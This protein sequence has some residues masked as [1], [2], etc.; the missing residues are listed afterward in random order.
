VSRRARVFRDLDAASAAL[1]RRL[2]ASARSAVRRHGRFSMVISGGKTPAGL[3]E[4]W[5]TTD[6]RRFPWARTEVFFAD[7]RCVPPTAAESNFGA[8]WHAFLSR[9]PIPRHR[10]HR[11][12]GELKP[13]SLAA[14]RYARLV[15]PVGVVASPPTP[16]FDVVLLGIGPDGH[17]ASLFPGSPA[18]QE[19]RRAVVDVARSGLAPFVPR[20]TLTP[21]ALS[22]AREVYFLVAGTDKA[23]AVAGIFRAKPSGD[24]RFPASLVRPP[25]ESVWFLDRDAAE[26]LPSATS[27]L[28]R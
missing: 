14:R 2:L 15:G 21:P 13:P 6:R 8:A 20:L 23:D 9:V 28:G 18:V 17:T 26:L 7:E 5:G 11:L 10:I 3:Y 4:R 19:A 22:A 24:L 16:R 25:E 1:S 12:R 27:G